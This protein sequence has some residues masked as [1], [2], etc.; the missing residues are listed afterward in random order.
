LEEFK[1]I[2]QNGN[3][4]D[5]FLELVFCILTPQSKAKTCWKAALTLKE[6]DLLFSDDA[7]SISNIIN[8]VRFKNKKAKFIIMAKKTFFI[9]E[10]FS[11]KKLISE[12]PDNHEA[13]AWFVKNIKGIGLKEASHFLRNIGF[14]KNLAILDRHILKN[15]KFFGIIDEVP[16]NLS[17]KKYFEIEKKMKDFSNKIKIDM[18]SLDFILWFKEAKEVFK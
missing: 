8:S 6:K 17:E 11:I 13:R 1:N 5:I 2:Y 10:G 12:F 9:N 14:G 18:E 3:D 15:L 7:G 4:K 16:Q